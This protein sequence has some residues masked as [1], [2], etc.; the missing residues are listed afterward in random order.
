MYLFEVIVLN[1]LTLG[2]HYMIY[3]VAKLELLSLF[4]WC[5][6]CFTAEIYSYVIL[7]LVSDP[8]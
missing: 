5:I 2:F 4:I 8:S 3:L 6:Y 1:P 7:F